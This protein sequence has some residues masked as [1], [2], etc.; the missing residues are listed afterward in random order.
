M[1]GTSPTIASLLA[2][3]SRRL[4]AA[5]VGEP[6]LDAELLL[7]HVL[8]WDRGTLVSRSGESVDAA[9]R[10]RFVSLVVERAA[11]RPLQH[12]LGIQAFWRHEFVVTPDVL[13][14]RPET[15]LL[16]EAA[17]ARLRHLPQPAIVDVGTGSGCIALSL[18]AELPAA[19]VDAVDVSAAALA[20]ARVNAARLGLA[21]RLRF[22]EGDLLE[23][24]RGRRFDAVL[25][26]PPY[27]DRSGAD[28]LSPEVR[29]HEPALALFPPG[30]D[31]YAVYRRLIPQA[32]AALERGGLLA[33]E[34][35]QGMAD[36]VAKLCGGAGF[37]LESVLQDLQGIPRTLLAR[38]RA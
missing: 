10:E 18:C 8:G 31:P 5:G 1:T 30:D 9:A 35:G 3:A 19:T 6:A 26:N 37:E 22:H 29:D 33:L 34:V 2:D 16:V 23:P 11:R 32:H 38:G 36:T 25:S 12:L 17:L 27:V 21:N 20:V 28:R 4:T 7:R 15:E 14:P 13:I 24:L